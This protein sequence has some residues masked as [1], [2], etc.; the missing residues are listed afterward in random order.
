MTAAKILKARAMENLERSNEAL[1][2]FAYI[3]SHDL[4]EPTRMVISYAQ[5]LERTQSTKVD[6]QG[7]KFLKFLSEGAQR[8]SSLI[9]DLLTYSRIN[10]TEQNVNKVDCNEVV[11]V[12]LENLSLQISNAKANVEV[13][14][15][16]QILGEFSQLVQVSLAKYQAMQTN[17]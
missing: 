14:P 9:Q 5:L 7:K 6:E 10:N 16:P 2:Q 11:E 17:T 13:K 1:E 4:Q 12:V 3:V 8:M 15:L